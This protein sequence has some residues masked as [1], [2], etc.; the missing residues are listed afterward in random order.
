M[1]IITRFFTFTSAIMSF[2]SCARA[3]LALIHEHKEEHKTHEC[4]SS[5]VSQVCGAR[6]TADNHNGFLTSALK[7]LSSLHAAPSS[8][9]QQEE[10]QWRASIP[11]LCEL[12][13]YSVTSE[14]LYNICKFCCCT[15][16]RQ[17][18]GLNVRRLPG[19]I[20]KLHNPAL[21]QPDWLHPPMNHNSNR[22]QTGRRAAA[23]IQQNV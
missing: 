9:R 20:S 22:K 21:L 11:S 7:S 23:E 6:R 1:S 18:I 14:L 15:R 8:Q 12:R 16:Q 5:A 17:R 2:S 3:H 10:A 4:H 19:K 13:F